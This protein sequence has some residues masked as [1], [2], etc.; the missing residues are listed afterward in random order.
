MNSL[1]FPYL[2]IY[3]TIPKVA[4]CLFQ[5]KLFLSIADTECYLSF[6]CTFH[7][8]VCQAL[9]SASVAA[10]CHQRWHFE[11]KDWK[12][13]KGLSKVAFISDFFRT[14]LVRLGA[15]S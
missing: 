13:Q 2:F 8:S 15:D 10:I 9:L 6:R 1:K 3:K 5:K 11:W 7:S 4:F 12:H 14:F